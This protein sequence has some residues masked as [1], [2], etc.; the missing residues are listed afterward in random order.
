MLADSACR[1]MPPLPHKSRSFTA[2]P[3]PE[4]ALPLL[5]TIADG[6]CPFAAA[7]ADMPLALYGAGNLGR[8][9][10]DFLKNVG[11]DL[12]MVLDRN[13]SALAN[14]PDWAGVPLLKPEEVTEA[15]KRE[16]R[17]ALSVVTTPYVPLERSL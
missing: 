9:A 15:A 2:L 14:E 6:T 16:T 12:V 13:A 1:S 11:H 7:I 8:L 3:G 4:Q 17:L 5:N 10:R